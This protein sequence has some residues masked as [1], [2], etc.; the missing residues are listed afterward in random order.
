MLGIRFGLGLGFAALLLT[1]GG[2]G[3]S[4][5][6]ADEQSGGDEEGVA[7]LSG[8]HVV[9]NPPADA[10]ENDSYYVTFFAY[11]T[12]NN[13][14]IT[15]ANSH[16]FA[17]FVHVKP[18]GQGGGSFDVFIKQAVTSAILDDTAKNGPITQAISG[19]QR[20]FGGQ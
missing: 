5:T 9:M 20:A 8:A 17:N 11:Q 2:A 18:D 4:S 13:I 6:S 10:L 14:L 7:A 16:T 3:C 12:G 19:K 1:I 15:K